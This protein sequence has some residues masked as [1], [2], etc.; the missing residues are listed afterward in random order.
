MSDR[1]LYLLGPQR[2]VPTVRDALDELDLEGGALGICTAGWEER[3]HETSEFERHV[4]EDFEVINLEVFERV[5]RCLLNDSQLRRAWQRRNDRRRTIQDLYDLRLGHA[6]A[7]VRELST[8]DDDQDLLL[9]QWTEAIA[10]VREL[11]RAHEQRI[12]DLHR[13]F[14]EVDRAHDFASVKQ[15]RDELSSLLER[16]TALCIAGGHVGTLLDRIR[17]LDLLGLFER[18][19]SQKRPVLAWSAGAMALC[20]RVVLFHDSPPEGAGNAE[21]WDPAF[22]IVPGIVPLPHAN[23]RLRLDDLSRVRIFANRFGEDRLV[24]LDPGTKIRCEGTSLSAVTNDVRVLER[25][26]SVQ[27]VAPGDRLGA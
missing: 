21:V 24:L 22:E 18:T 13:D 3:E 4:G 9:P 1:A 5:E 23:H 6:L 2:H 19:E 26:G 17:L 20:S 25:D 14:F 8:R 10:A 12:A 16:C 11:D 7:A 15:S 27:S